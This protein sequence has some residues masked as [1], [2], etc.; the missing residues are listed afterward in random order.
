MILSLTYFT[1]YDNLQIHSHCCKWHSFI[2]VKKTFHCFYWACEIQNLWYRNL[3]LLLLFSIIIF[4]FLLGFSK[5][6][7]ENGSYTKEK[8]RM[9]LFPLWACFLKGEWKPPR[10][11]SIMHSFIHSFIEQSSTYTCQAL[12]QVLRIQRGVRPIK[13]LRF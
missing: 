11:L 4:C 12:Y 7:S 2:S 1:Q 13:E 5:I 3:T 9:G 10:R 8:Q 6:P